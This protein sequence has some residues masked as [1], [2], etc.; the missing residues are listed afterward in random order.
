MSN[1]GRAIRNNISQRRVE[2]KIKN[3]DINSRNRNIDSFRPPNF[4]GKKSESL[5]SKCEIG[6]VDDFLVN[7]S[8]SRKNFVLRSRQDDIVLVEN[9]LDD[10]ALKKDLSRS[11]LSNLKKMAN[12]NKSELLEDIKVIRRP[13]WDSATDP[14]ELAFSEENAFIDWK[15]DLSLRFTVYFT[16]I[17]NFKFLN[18]N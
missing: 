5:A 3:S 4:R 14:N 15:K 11:G 18:K 12:L 1:L 16:K 8:R 9:G 13:R 17:A 2:Q 6:T 10:L 7:V